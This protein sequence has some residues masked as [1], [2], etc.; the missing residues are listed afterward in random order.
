[1]NAIDGVAAVHPAT[2]EELTGLAALE[3]ASA[4]LFTAAGLEL[5]PDILTVDELK[6][7]EIVLVAPGPG[8]EPV[9]FAMVDLLDGGAH[10]TQLSVHPDHGR[11]GIGRGL[12]AA[13][14]GRAR[15]SGLPVV[16]LTTFRDVPW[17]GPFYQRYGFVEVPD[18]ELTPGVKA[19]RDHEIEIGLDAVAPRCAM[20]RPLR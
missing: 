17:N 12:L 5:P 9:G 20:R 7:S 1:M 11:R 3:E 6:A 15:R 8:G 10:L 13:V 16:T 18:A 4:A 14:I 2:D 19:H